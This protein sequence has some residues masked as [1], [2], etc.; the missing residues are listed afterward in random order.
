ML[1]R[2]FDDKEQYDELMFSI[3]HTIEAFDDATYAK[4]LVRSLP[5][6]IPNAPRWCSIVHMRI[7]NSTSALGA[8]VTE[9]KSAEEDTK[10]MLRRMIVQM[11]ARGAQIA[12]KT[13]PLLK[14]LN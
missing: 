9:I 2:C 7:L 4:E 11:G 14:A 6:F 1:I 5:H 13:V 8:Y 10:S 12:N 3:V